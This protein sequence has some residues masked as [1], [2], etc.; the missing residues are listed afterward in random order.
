MPEQFQEPGSFHD[1]EGDEHPL[2]RR[3]R[4]RVKGMMSKTFVKTPEEL[5][6]VLV[7]GDLR[8]AFDHIDAATMPRKSAIANKQEAVFEIWDKHL[9]DQR[10]L[11][12]FP[13]VYLGA[14]ND[15][16]YPLALG[17]RKM[18]LVDPYLRDNATQAKLKGRIESLG[19]NP[20]LNS[21]TG[22]YTFNF[23][24][25]EGPESV[26]L[27]S[28]PREFDARVIEPEDEDGKFVA[29]DEV[30]MYVVFQGP[31]VS[32]DREALSKVV[33]GGYILSNHALTSLLTEAGVFGE[34]SRF[35]EEPAYE[36]KLEMV[37]EVYRS[38]GFES[39]P[40][41]SKKDNNQFTFLR[42]K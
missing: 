30:G 24:F 28:D 6:R 12:E 42:K 29:P 3:A 37:E 19:A 5:E 33:P 36:K 20:T 35:I 38:F 23:D 40:L 26:E 10:I 31:D 16:E 13:T 32:A 18:R 8:K 34:G 2:Q 25:G 4:E 9:L 39:L 21:E 17:S 27:V 1:E 7:T 22:L 15:V 11:K 14:G 41:D